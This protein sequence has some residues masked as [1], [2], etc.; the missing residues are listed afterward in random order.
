MQEINIKLNYTKILKIKAWR[1]YILKILLQ[2]KLG[3]NRVILVKADVARLKL[4]KS[5]Y[6]RNYY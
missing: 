6:L 4:E 5:N 3:N 2:I 1:K